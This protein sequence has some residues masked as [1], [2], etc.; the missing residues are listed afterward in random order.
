MRYG[1]VVLS[2]NGRPTPDVEAYV[3]AR[4]ARSDGLTVVVF[5]DGREHTL[6][7]PLE[8]CSAPLTRPELQRTAQ[9][10]AAARLVP[11]ELPGEPIP[12]SESRSA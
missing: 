1:D 4:N 11:L 9:Q 3:E 2:V 5:R 6:E 7:V 8:P 12:P 10:L